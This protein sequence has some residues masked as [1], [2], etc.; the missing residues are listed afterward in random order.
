MF[1]DKKNFFL[2]EVIFDFWG[3]LWELIEN[4]LLFQ[5][6]VDEFLGE[7]FFLCFIYFLN[8]KFLFKDFFNGKCMV[9]GVCFM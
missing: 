3:N 8:K 4:I 5:K 1:L 6:V 7:I 9:L 2:M